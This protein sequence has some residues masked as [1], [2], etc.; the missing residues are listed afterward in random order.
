[1]NNQLGNGTILP[2]GLLSHNP[3]AHLD[4]FRKTFQNTALKVGVITASYAI[5]DPNNIHKL[6]IEYDVLAFEQKENTGTSV[7]TYKNC[8]AAS[9]LGGLADY[10]EMSL[11][12]IEKLTTK[13]PVPQSS[14][15]NGSIVLLLCLNGLSDTAVIIGALGHPD[16][17][18]NLKTDEPHLEG[19]Y[20]G[21]NIVV[22][23][24]G[25]TSLTFKGA[26]DND[27]NPTD[28]TQGDTELSIETDGSY[29]VMHKT[30]TQ[31][32]DKN[33]KFDLTTTDDISNTTQTNFN[34]TTTK[35]VN[36]N[37]TGDMNIASNKFVVNAQGSAQLQCQKL[38]VQSES[39]LDFSGSN[40][41]V[42]AEAMASIKAP[43][44]TL[45][46]IC[47]L[48]GSGGQPLLTI[49]TMMIG[50]GNLGG[51]VVSQAISGFTLKTFAT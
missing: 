42:E 30:I 26:T 37:A 12:K 27:G 24:D 17:P 31:R 9:S 41:T 5:T 35:D 34:V 22:N 48:G 20:N 11:R 46:G 16:R 6:F 51:I 1:M 45:D 49:T 8:P 19:E 13:G 43:T 36:V 38:A 33:G 50:V 29:Q 14:G 40:F 21:V 2:S 28:T 7:S 39:D 3:M 25:S 10:F 15:N 18:T 23:P 47:F 4:S 44:V 32:L